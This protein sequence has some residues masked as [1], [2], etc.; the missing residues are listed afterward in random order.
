MLILHSSPGSSSL[1]AHIL[2]AEAGARYRVADVPISEGAHRTAGFLALN[3]KGRVPVLETPDGALTET[4]AILEYIACTHPDAGL[5]PDGAFAR[6]RARSLCAYLCATA[7]VAFA[8][9]QRGDRWASRDS[10]FRDMQRK[11]AGNLAD[12]AAIVEGAFGPGPWATGARYGFCDPYLLV[13]TRWLAAADV[14]IEAFP[15][16]AAH[17]DAIR[18]R[19]ATRAV[20][21]LHGLAGNG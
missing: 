20:L 2:L 1:A 5:L 15:K 14:R 3:P 18:S 21:A 8:H 12:C 10:S 11:V 17:R 19:P 6:A 4:P 13:F 16:L 9:R 7:H